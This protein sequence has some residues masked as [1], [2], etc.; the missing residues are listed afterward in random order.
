MES[1]RP[2]ENCFTSGMFVCIF[3]RALL[4]CL[5]ICYAVFLT[6]FFS[7]IFFPPCLFLPHFLC[8]NTI[9]LLF[10]SSLFLLRLWKVLWFYFLPSPPSASFSYCRS[11]IDLLS[12]IRVLPLGLIWDTIQ[13]IH[14]HFLIE[15]LGE[16][17]Y[18]PTC[19]YSLW[20]FQSPYCIES[21][22]TR[23]IR[24]CLFSHLLGTE[25]CRL[26][27]KMSQVILCFPCAVSCSAALLVS[28][29]SGGFSMIDS[30]WCCEVKIYF[31]RNF[32]V[33]RGNS[34]FLKVLLSL[35]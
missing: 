26:P 23:A 2:K 34:V 16:R 28:L 19:F 20:S 7:V 31:F 17:R 13:T 15:K 24:W 21:T 35:L 5:S 14:I 22:L 10:N 33:G 29:L 18:F 1:S 12:D 25:H 3:P 11:F 30:C 4:V 32:T 9:W 6:D 8:L 27:C